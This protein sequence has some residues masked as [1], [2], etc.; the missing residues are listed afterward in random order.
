MGVEAARRLLLPGNL[1][2]LGGHRRLRA[3]PGRRAA[4][5]EEGALQLPDDRLGAGGG[6]VARS[7]GKGRAAGLPLPIALVRQD[8]LLARACPLAPAAL[9]G[10]PA[11]WRTVTLRL[12]PS[13][14]GRQELALENPTLHRAEPLVHGGRG[15]LHVG[16][17]LG[18]SPVLLALILQLLKEDLEALPA[19]LRALI[20]V[21]EDLLHQVAVVVSCGG[22]QFDKLVHEIL[23]PLLH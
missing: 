11:A 22:E 5:C 14:R 20:N 2:P 21:R 3:G 7:F 1:L 23:H 18:T 10:W 19:L 6:A 15:D 4:F 8:H 16:Q 13:G 17:A 9:R 12:S